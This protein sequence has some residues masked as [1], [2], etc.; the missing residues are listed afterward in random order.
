[1]FWLFLTTVFIFTGF[2]IKFFNTLLKLFPYA[3]TKQKAYYLSTLNSLVISLCSLYLNIQF[4]TSNDI[5]YNSLIIQVL[6]ISF[7]TSYLLCDILIGLFYYK[8]YIGIL[9]GYIHHLIYICINILSI[10]L[11]STLVYTLFLI[12]EIPTIFLC[13]GNLNSKFRIDKLFGFLFFITRICYHI[14]LITLYY[15]PF[16]YFPMTKFF[17]QDS[18]SQKLTT[19]LAMSILGLHLHWFSKWY[20]KYF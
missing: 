3:T 11:N 17:N 7:F 16:D 10:W 12:S 9:T 4:F 5:S 15:L 2:Q 14:F 18:F 1:M 13:I 19:T 20:T 6:C 8:Q